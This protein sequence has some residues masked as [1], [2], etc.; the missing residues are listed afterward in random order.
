MRSLAAFRSA[1]NLVTLASNRLFCT[2]RTLIFVR[3]AF[4]TSLLTPSRSE[5]LLTSVLK[6]CCRLLARVSLSSALMTV[7]VGLES[8]VHSPA[9]R[10]WQWMQIRHSVALALAHT[11]QAVDGFRGDRWDF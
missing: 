5:W 10:R 8:L 2:L 3:A 11:A 6:S 9:I 4:S 1:A 7:A